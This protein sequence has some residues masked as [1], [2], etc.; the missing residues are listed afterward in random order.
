MT[1]KRDKPALYLERMNYV[2]CLHQGAE[3]ALCFATDAH[4]VHV[5]C[6]R[7]QMTDYWGPPK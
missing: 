2:I 5:E 6:W 4:R 7:T 1:R 3:G